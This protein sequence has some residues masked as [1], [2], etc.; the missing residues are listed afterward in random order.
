MQ[1]DAAATSF[2]PLSG[3]QYACSTTR[4]SSKKICRRGVLSAQ[5]ALCGYASA[6]VLL[7]TIPGKDEGLT[8]DMDQYNFAVLVHDQRTRN[9]VYQLTSYSRVTVRCRA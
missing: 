9:G 5:F 4:N 6:C 3:L 2:L 8:A 7:H 1:A